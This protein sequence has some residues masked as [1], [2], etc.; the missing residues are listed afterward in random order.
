MMTTPA[1]TSMASATHLVRKMI[2]MIKKSCAN[3]SHSGAEITTDV[4][5]CNCC[6]DMEFYDQLPESLCIEFE[7]NKPM[8][9]FK[10]VVKSEATYFVKDEEGVMD[11]KEAMGIAVDWF[12]EREPEVYCEELEVSSFP[13]VDAYC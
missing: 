5:C 2:G 1:V 8:K 3:C 7:E 11:E 10:I 13:A 6:E 9:I 12:L 4:A